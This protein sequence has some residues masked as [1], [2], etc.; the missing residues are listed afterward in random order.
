MGVELFRLF[1]CELLV[2]CCSRLDGCPDRLMDEPVKHLEAR[3]KILN[4]NSLVEA[5]V[6]ST[7][8][9]PEAWPS[10]SSLLPSALMRLEVP[11]VES[12]LATG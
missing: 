12:S 3:K 4:H 11:T 6:F 2:F 8:A 10:P 7:L 1:G 9:A 5:S